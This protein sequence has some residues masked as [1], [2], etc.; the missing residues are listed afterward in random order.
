MHSGARWRSRF[1]LDQRAGRR[2]RR[3]AP[4]RRRGGAGGVIRR[5]SPMRMPAIPVPGTSLPSRGS[6]RG[7][8]GE[9]VFGRR[10]REIDAVEVEQPPSRDESDAAPA[11]LRRRCPR[12][13]SCSLELGEGDVL[14]LRAGVCPPRPRS[15][16]VVSAVGPARRRAPLPGTPRPRAEVRGRTRGVAGRSG[17]PRPGGARTPAATGRTARATDAIGAC[18][19]TELQVPR[20]R[21]LGSF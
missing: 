19:P 16:S 21:R 17:A 18:V 5:I 20:P 12:A 7:G 3:R 15:R 2:C 4:R 14:L 13:A 11:L 1:E 9:F 10:I 6:A 8:P